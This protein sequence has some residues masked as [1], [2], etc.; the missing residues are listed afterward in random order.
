MAAPGV[1]I[2]LNM[3]NQCP[4]DS[5]RVAEA[6]IRGTMPEA[7]RTRY[8]DHYIA[9]RACAEILQQTDEYIHAMCA[10]ARRL[11]EVPAG[12][13]EAEDQTDPGDCDS[14]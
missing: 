3:L 1:S 5:E 6:Y 9:C 11:R 7:E 12:T 8:E 13:G 2:G 14:Q 10:A 4:R